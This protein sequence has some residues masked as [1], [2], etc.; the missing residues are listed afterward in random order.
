M[1][2]DEGARKLHG[3]LRIRLI[4]VN[5]KANGAAIDSAAPVDQRLKR[6]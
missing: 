2:S 4:V 6:N 1:R 3:D 5:V